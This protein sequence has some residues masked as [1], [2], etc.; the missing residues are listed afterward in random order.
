M[1]S[2]GILFC[3]AGLATPTSNPAG[4]NPQTEIWRRVEPGSGPRNAYIPS[5]RR[6]EYR[7]D[8]GSGSASNRQGLPSE[9]GTASMESRSWG[10]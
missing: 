10:V 4:T 6:R 7:R 8:R 9:M 5:A 2:D 1:R 3:V